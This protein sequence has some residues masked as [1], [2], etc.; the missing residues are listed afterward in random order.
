MKAKLSTIILCLFQDFASH[1]ASYSEETKSAMQETC[2]VDFTQ[3]QRTEEHFVISCAKSFLPVK[4]SL[5]YYFETYKIPKRN[6]V[7]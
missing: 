4:Y 2:L 7:L 6:V 3:G 5:F 1:A